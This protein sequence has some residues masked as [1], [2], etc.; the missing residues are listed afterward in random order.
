MGSLKKQMELTITRD[1]DCGFGVTDSMTIRVTQV[2]N[3]LFDKVAEDA[4]EQGFNDNVVYAR[5]ICGALSAWEVMGPVPIETVGDL[6][7]GS[8]V[9][10]GDPIPLDPEVVRHLPLPLLEGMMIGI[11]SAADPKRPPARKPT[12]ES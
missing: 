11:R 2:S 5:M 1:V 7:E 8:V 3:D 10:D 12:P 6:E 9:K 4:R